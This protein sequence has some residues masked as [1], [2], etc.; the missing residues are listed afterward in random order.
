MSLYRATLLNG[1]SVFIKVV[2][3]LVLNKILAIYIGPSGY[4]IVGQLQNAVS[5][6]S[7]VAGGAIA[8]GVTR[9]TAQHFDNE[10]YQRVVW[11]T[12]TRITVVAAVMTSVGL[13]L[14]RDP[15]SA[16]VLQQQ[17]MA[18]VFLWLALSIPAMAFNNLLLAI[19][20]G[21]KRID[22]Y[23]LANI[24][25]S[26]VGL[27]ITAVLTV[28]FGLRGAFIAFVVSPAVVL[29]TTALL[30]ARKTQI[31]L[32]ELFGRY[33]SS[34]ASLLAGYGAMGITTAIA[35][36]LSA[37]AVREILSVTLGLEAAGYWQAS[38]KISEIY[39][40]LITTTLSVYYLPRLAE[41]RSARELSA[42]IL[43]VYKLVLPLAVLCALTIYLL[44]DF[45]IISLFTTHFY[46]MRDL[47]SWQLLGDVIK[48]GSWVPAYI[49]LGR[50]MT[51]VFVISEVVFAV[52][53]VLLSSV[54]ITSFGLVG[55]P[56][57]YLANYV[58]YWIF[59]GILLRT[60]IR[61]IAG[62]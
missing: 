17:G 38:W 44:R 16:R 26:V 15:I 56:M 58:A 42:E 31:N 52:T 13:I 29:L 3:A 47:F 39:L 25:G 5:I 45:I 10:I 21:R 11:R 1:L 23:V 36:P 12:A 9:M 14:F 27:A 51:K 48:I 40:M 28:F 6:A 19:L 22:L 30:A 41:I 57:A 37:I 49:M 62:A 34:A 50:G 54:L 33:D 60:E 2:S 4:A 8:A 7:N 18:D 20:N 53:L 61:K 59:A 46:P 35:A 43:K 55:A 32:A 24:S